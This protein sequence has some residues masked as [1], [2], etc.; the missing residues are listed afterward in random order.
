MM[1]RLL[2]VLAV[3]L[4]APGLA[5]AAE[6]PS[7]LVGV[8]DHFVALKGFSCSFEQTI[9]FSDGSRQV[10]R[11]DLAVLP[12]GRFRWHYS[13]PYEQLFVSDGKQIWQYE[14]DLMQVKILRHMQ[15]VDPAVMQLLDG[16]LESREVTLIKADKDSH[17]YY[18]RIGAK[19]KVWLGLAPPH[20]LA[21]VEN[22]DTLGNRNRIHLL[23]IT[24]RPPDRFLFTFAIPRGVDVLPLE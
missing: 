11:G 12:P 2:F 18:V 21:Y 19:T 10:Y 4:M 7:E 3:A 22:I 13:E 9:R 16:R 6:L 15:G 20:N 8:L 23:H 17:R 5:A 24:A 1:R 14:P